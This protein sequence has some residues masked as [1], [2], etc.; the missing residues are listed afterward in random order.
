MWVERIIGH[1]RKSVYRR[2]IVSTAALS[3]AAFTFISAAR[4]ATSS[5]LDQDV[6]KVYPMYGVAISPVVKYGP[7]NPTV[8][9]V[10]NTPTF[11]GFPSF[12]W[13]PQPIHFTAPTLGQWFPSFPKLMGIATSDLLATVA[14]IAYVSLLMVAVLGFMVRGGAWQLKNRPKN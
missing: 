4:A 11:T 8:M 9:P 3:S 14:L 13:N 6:G 1:F 2:L 12:S 5:L 7:P 10:T